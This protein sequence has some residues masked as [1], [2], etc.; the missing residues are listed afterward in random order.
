MPCDDR[1]TVP[2]LGLPPW[3]APALLYCWNR[4]GRT[5]PPFASAPL[6][7]F[8]SLAGCYFLATAGIAALA[9]QQVQPLADTLATRAALID[10]ARR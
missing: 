5:V 8:A 4:T 2:I 1:G 10:A 9:Q 6:K 7:L 3:Q